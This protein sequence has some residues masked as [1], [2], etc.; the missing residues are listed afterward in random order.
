MDL[1]TRMWIQ[2][3]GAALLALLG[4][5]ELTGLKDPTFDA[6]WGP[7]VLVGGATVMLFEAWRTRRKIQK[8]PEGAAT[9][10]EDSKLKKKEEIA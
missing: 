1:R 4:A 9:T 10:T 7:W 6:A 3:G 8:L 2:I 5:A